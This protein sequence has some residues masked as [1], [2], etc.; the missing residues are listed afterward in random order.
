MR[1]LAGLLTLVWILII[2][3]P[4][5]GAPSAS[6]GTVEDQRPPQQK[7][8]DDLMQKALQDSRTKKTTRHR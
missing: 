8:N 6:S 3:L 1:R 2:M 4:G 5:C 7:K